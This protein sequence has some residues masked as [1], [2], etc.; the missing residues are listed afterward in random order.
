MVPGLAAVCRAG[1]FL[2]SPFPGCPEFRIDIHNHSP[3]FKQ[4]VLDTLANGKFR[5]FHSG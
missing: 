5:L 1:R 3:V 4:P 2:Q